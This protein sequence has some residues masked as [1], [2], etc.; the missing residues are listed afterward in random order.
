VTVG[1]ATDDD[2]RR[3]GWLD[4]GTR[5]GVAAAVA[6]GRE[7]A[8][9]LVARDGG[10]PVGVLAVDLPPWRGR[11][12]PWLWLVEV[13]PAHRGRGT[14]TALP[15][16]AH[17]VLAVLGHPVAELGVADANP[18]AR[19]LYERLGYRV[20]GRGADTGPAGPEPWTRMRRDPAGV[21]EGV[22]AGG[23]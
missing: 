19:T 16:A 11:A 21:Q 13:H 23:C 8:L 7:S 4:D 6:A 3:L 15:D 12:R 17:H 9:V 5:D 20:T 14:G 1:P 2:V 22:R 18:R 10:A